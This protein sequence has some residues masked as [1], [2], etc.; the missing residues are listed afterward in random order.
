LPS[1]V[2]FGE[3]PAFVG[4]GTNAI[5]AELMDQRSRDFWLEGKRTGDFRRNPGAVPYVPATGQPY[6][7]PEQG[8]VRDNTCFPVPRVEIDNNPNF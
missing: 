6:Y 1:G 5:L 4:V 7:K 2:Q 3:Q 8:A